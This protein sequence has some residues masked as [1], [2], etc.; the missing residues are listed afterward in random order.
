MSAIPLAR[1]DCGRRQSLLGKGEIKR[2]FERDVD[3]PSSP[4]LSVETRD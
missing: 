4:R 3:D 1:R 2:G